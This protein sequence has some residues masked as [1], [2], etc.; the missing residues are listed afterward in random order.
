MS[1]TTTDL[2]EQE[3]PEIAPETVVETPAAEQTTETEQPEQKPSHGDRRFANLTARNASMQAELAEERRLREAAE[4]LLAAKEDKPEDSR[5]QP[6]VDRET[7]KA[8]VR[9]E[10]DRDALLE[11]GDAAFGKAEFKAQVDVLSSLGAF[12]SGAFNQAL[13]A[14]PNGEKIVAALAEDTD[15]LI[16]MLGKS[17][18]ALA[19]EMGRMS[20]KL[21]TATTTTTQPTVRVSQA[22]RPMTPVTPAP[23]L[24]EPDLYDPKT[25]DDMDAYVRQYRKQFGERKARGL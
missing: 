21:E 6:R 19:A 9:F 2:T 3:P 25:T 7:I 16:S 13:V 15:A 10:Q 5:P 1:E 23:V 4:A 24:A 8:E 18:A 20:A 17:P 14:M 22:P 12:G 11:R